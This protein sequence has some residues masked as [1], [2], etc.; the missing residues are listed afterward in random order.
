VNIIEV[1]RKRGIKFFNREVNSRYLQRSTWINRQRHLGKKHHLEIEGSTG[2]GVR[3]F[4][5]RWKISPL[6]GSVKS[7]R[8]G[9][10]KSWGK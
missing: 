3:G 1:E 6:V 2:E 9:G 10:T 7:V 8:R 4:E 5:R